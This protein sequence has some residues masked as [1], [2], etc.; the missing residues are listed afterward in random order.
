MI[1]ILDLQ[2]C[3]LTSVSSAVYNLGFDYNIIKIEERNKL[4][5]ISHLIIPG[6]GSFSNI[7]KEYFKKPNDHYCYEFIC[8]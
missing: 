1:G 7:S 5:K 2:V 6:V 4:D 3:N 8:Y